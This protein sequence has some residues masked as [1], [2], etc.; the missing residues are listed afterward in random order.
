MIN[1]P[2]GEKHKG[3]LECT[4]GHNIV[5][6]FAQGKKINGFGYCGYCK[7]VLKLNFSEI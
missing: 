7:K 1:M 6:I 3:L 4:C 2:L 5:S